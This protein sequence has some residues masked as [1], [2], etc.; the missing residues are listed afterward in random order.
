MTI[1]IPQCT[2]ITRVFCNWCIVLVYCNASRAGNG[3]TGEWVKWVNL[4]WSVGHLGHGS[5][6]VHLWPMYRCTRY[7]YSSTSYH[8]GTFI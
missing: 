8:T 3:S 6:Y 2:Q 1:I 7:V 4:R 5:M